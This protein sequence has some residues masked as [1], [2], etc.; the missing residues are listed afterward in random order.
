MW[1]IIVT[2]HGMI[3]IKFKISVYWDVTPCSLAE[4]YQ[5][6]EETCRLHIQGRTLKK[7]AAGSSKMLMFFHSTVQHDIQVDCNLHSRQHKNLKSH[8]V[9]LFTTISAC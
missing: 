5:R 1:V 7:D 4:S 6:S 2:M 3:N 9:I 8:C